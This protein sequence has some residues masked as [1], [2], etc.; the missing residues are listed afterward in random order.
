MKVKTIASLQNS[1]SN[2]NTR[3]DKLVDK[4]T[5][6]SDLTDIYEKRAYEDLVTAADKLNEAWYALDKVQGD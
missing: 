5:A 3:V 4:I 1:I 2:V 6:E